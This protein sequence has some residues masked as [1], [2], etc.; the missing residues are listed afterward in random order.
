MVRTLT[1]SRCL[2]LWVLGLSL[3]GRAFP[4][5]AHN[6]ALAIA[7]P[8]E[9]IKIDGDFSDWPKEMKRYAITCPRRVTGQRMQ[10]TSMETSASA[11][12]EQSFTPAL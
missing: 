4:A 6:G 10:P 9:G 1:L 3:L 5:A 11:T 2:I 8:V 12:T 7:V